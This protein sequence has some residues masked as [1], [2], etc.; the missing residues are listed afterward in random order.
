MQNIIFILEMDENVL[1]FVY[2]GIGTISERHP[3]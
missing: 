1:N 2:A 3:H